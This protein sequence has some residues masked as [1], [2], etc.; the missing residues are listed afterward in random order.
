MI[1]DLH[2]AI[3]IAYR[4]AIRAD[5]E[6]DATAAFQAA[7]D[8]LLA[9]HPEIGAEPACRLT[10]RMIERGPRGRRGSNGAPRR[11]RD[12]GEHSSRCLS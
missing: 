5:P 12:A 3:W 4:R 1:D 8:V 10:V 9:R 6:W 7:V 11:R 2:R